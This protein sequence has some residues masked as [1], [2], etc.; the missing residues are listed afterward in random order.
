MAS[1][2]RRGRRRSAWEPLHGLRRRPRA[3]DNHPY[4]VARGNEGPLLEELVA[5]SPPKGGLAAFV[6]NLE[7]TQETSDE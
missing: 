3:T 1:Q 7:H 4:Y 5:Q 6:C 2:P